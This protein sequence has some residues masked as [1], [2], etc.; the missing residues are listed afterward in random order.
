M[1]DDEAHKLE[2][3]YGN[4]IPIAPFTG[5]SDDTAPCKTA[6]NGWRF[7]LAVKNRILP[8]LQEEIMDRRKYERS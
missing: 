3:N 4:H 7:I 8:F 1:V 6:N 2:R 5:T